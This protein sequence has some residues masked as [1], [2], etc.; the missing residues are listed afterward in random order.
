MQIILDEDM[1]Q[2]LSFALGITGSLFR[3]VL[4][5]C[6]DY[7]KLT[8]DRESVEYCVAEAGHIAAR[9]DAMVKVAHAAERAQEQAA[10]DILSKV[11]AYLQD[12]EGRS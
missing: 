11:A 7:L 10:E 4:A 6:P 3:D 5:A 12:Q 2:D 9:F 1:I 8:A